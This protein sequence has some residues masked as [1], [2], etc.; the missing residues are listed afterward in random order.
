MGHPDI[1]C[2][3]RLT[4]LFCK[5]C[6][7][8]GG[9]FVILGQSSSVACPAPFGPPPTV[10][11]PLVKFASVLCN[12]CLKVP[13]HTG[14]RK[15]QLGG[16]G[17]LGCCTCCEFGP[18][19]VGWG[20]SPNPYG[21][22]M[23]FQANYP[24]CNCQESQGAD[25]MYTLGDLQLPEHAELSRLC[26]LGYRL[27]QQMVYGSPAFALK[28]AE[29]IPFIQSQLG[30]CRLAADTL[31]SMFH[32]NR[33]LLDEMPDRLVTC[34]VRLC[35]VRVRQAGYIKF[36]CELCVCDGQGVLKNQTV[37]C[38]H[39]LEENGALLLPLAV[40]GNTVVVNIPTDEQLR[41]A[42]RRSRGGSGEFP[43]P[44][45]PVKA[46]AERRASVVGG[47]PATENWVSLAVFYETASPRVKDFFAQTLELFA[48]L[49]VG[50]NM[51]TRDVVSKF[52]P[53]EV[54]VAVLGLDAVQEGV[55]DSVKSLFW[56]IASAVY[57][58]RPLH[59]ST[60]LGVRTAVRDCS[61]LEAGR[62]P[63]KAEGPSSPRSP[64]SSSRSSGTGSDTP[65]SDE[66]EDLAADQE[67]LRAM[68]AAATD[69]LRQ[70]RQQYL[71]QPY[72]SILTKQVLRGALGCE[73]LR[74]SP[75]SPALVAGR[76]EISFVYQRFH[77]HLRLAHLN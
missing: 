64:A 65:G 57:L 53:K 3:L 15:T 8:A 9:S 72:R 12:R 16:S 34:F 13:W 6:P 77:L 71:N 62:A 1:F 67:F 61:Q 54:L 76:C 19:N 14:A 51:R 28:L 45:T 55:P 26:A 21:L 70:N 66:Q 69:Y 50:G 2:R 18:G 17:G 74:R 4:T 37:I 60:V 46:G 10:E 47:K 40:H 38:K 30:Y 59:P 75:P 56:S 35:T 58:H 43:A 25:A 73:E 63:R 20:M 22:R 5:R 36:L 7:L 33:K 48:K 31:S 42:K 24:Y 32:N 41:L 11:Q 44:P 27:L 39:L 68:K 49:A 29:Y 52:V 23:S